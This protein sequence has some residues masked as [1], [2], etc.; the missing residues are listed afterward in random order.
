MSKLK[1]ADRSKG[2]SPLA[3]GGI[4]MGVLGLSA[5]IGRRNAPDPSHPG[6][7]KW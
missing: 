4:V 2:M 6:I 1:R 5:L 3:A 7:R